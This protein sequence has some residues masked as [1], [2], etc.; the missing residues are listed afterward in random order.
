MKR[1]LPVGV[2]LLL[3]LAGTILFLQQ[4][5]D[6]ENFLGDWYYAGDGTLYRF[7]EGILECDKYGYGLSDG[8]VFS[9]AYMFS[10]NCVVVFLVGAEGP[11][12]VKELYFSRSPQGN[13]LREGERGNGK[14]VFYRNREAAVQGE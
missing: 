12:E 2:V 14:V 6:P 9:G 5:V 3:L 1:W 8:S 11:E 4:G 13:V 7:R 10:K